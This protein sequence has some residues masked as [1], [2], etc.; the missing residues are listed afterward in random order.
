MIKWS[1]GVFILDSVSPDYYFATAFSI[2]LVMLFLCCICVK[3]VVEPI[4]ELP[5]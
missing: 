2:C 1:H 4:F 5:N 3:Y